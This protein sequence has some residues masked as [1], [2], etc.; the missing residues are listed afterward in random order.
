MLNA[1]MAAKMSFEEVALMLWAR[2]NN[3]EIVSVK[4]IPRDELEKEKDQ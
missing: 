3:I 4:Y 1:T 2:Q